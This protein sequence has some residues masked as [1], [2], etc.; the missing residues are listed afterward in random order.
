MAWLWPLI[1]PPEDYAEEA[2]YWIDA[3]RETIGP[4]DVRILELGV[5]GG[6]NLSHIVG[7]HGDM[8]V[9]ACAVDLSEGMLAHSRKL[10]PSVAHYVGD[11]RSVRL[12]D[13]SGG[14]S[15]FDAVLIHDAVSY[16]LSEDDITRTFDT[17]RVHL[18]PGGVLI[19]AP[20]WYRETF[21][22]PVFSEDTR[23]DDD[24]EVTML[25]T[26]FDSDPSDTVMEVAFT[27]EIRESGRL[28]IEEDQH[29][30]GLFPVDTWVRSMERAGF[31]VQLRPF[32]VHADGR[33]A[34]LITGVR[35]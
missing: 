13:E 26:E 18:R 4:G 33:D 22:P 1:S 20:D 24:T 12:R 9:S 32:P 6:D 19:I 16:L 3:L 29:E 34:W 8:V 25:S 11:M 14:V 31:A 27:F 2:R 28:R 10:N 15:T 21:H 17:V 23:S 35:S 5:G 7:D 30:M